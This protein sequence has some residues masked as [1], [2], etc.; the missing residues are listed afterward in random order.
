[1]RQ[2]SIRKPRF[3]AL[4][5]SENGAEQRQRFACTRGRLEQCVGVTISLGT[6]KR[7]YDP[8]HERKLCSVG[9]VREF[10]LKASDLVDIL[11]V[12]GV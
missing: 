12:F 3:V 4:L 2:I 1:M 5:P 10:N 7:R 6:I 11:R 8:A 9:L